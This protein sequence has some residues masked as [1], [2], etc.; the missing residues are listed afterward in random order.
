[1]P[2]IVIWQP[3]NPEYTYRQEFYAICHPVLWLCPVVNCCGNYLS[4]RYLSSALHGRL[5]HICHS[6]FSMFQIFK[7]F[8]FRQ[9]LPVVAVAWIFSWNFDDIY[10]S[11]AGISRLSVDIAISVYICWSWLKM[12][13]LA[14][15]NYAAFAV[16]K[17]RLE[18]TC[19]VLLVKRLS[20]WG[21]FSM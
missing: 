14:V 5:L 19:I 13:Q 21:F 6:T 20:L 11:F 4:T 12:F 9:P 16:V 2:E 10:D 18:N 17:T 8:Q 7:Y 15:A 3:K 1:M